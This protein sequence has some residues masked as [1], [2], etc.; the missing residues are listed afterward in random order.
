MFPVTAPYL[1]SYAQNG[2][3]V[4][5]WRALHG[6]AN[7]R[8]V[9]VGANSP[10]HFSITK[11]FYDAGWNG[12]TIEPVP[13]FAAQH[14]AQR[15]RD[16]LV[17]VA[18]TAD[19]VDTITLY[20]IP[21]TGL[22]T[23]VADISERHRDNGW[24]PHEIKVPARSLR[25]VLRENLEPGADI[26]FMTVDTEGSERAVLESMDFAT[27]RPWALVIE[28][29]APLTNAPTHDQWEDLVLS[30][31][32]QFCLF[33]GLSRYYVAEERAEELASPLSYPACVLDTFNRAL[34]E[35]EQAEK[36]ELVSL[37]ERVEGLDED[38]RNAARE[39]VRWR[40]LAIEGITTATRPVTSSPD[41]QQ[42]LEAMRRTISWR[43]TAPM[44]RLRPRMNRPVAFALKVRSRARSGR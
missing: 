37:R 32:Y 22:S 44:R 26:H 13:E 20:D 14:R 33:D 2:E 1:L 38:V 24:Q 11:A 31:G 34:S 15:P 36:D 19:P 10:T 16:T 9:E 30:A 43:I 12:I 5:L 18:I 6:V 23:A 27:W 21:D 4:V 40:A 42:E 39:V 35:Q 17:E 29:T 28:A 7:G 41:A 25:D 3:D 8:Y